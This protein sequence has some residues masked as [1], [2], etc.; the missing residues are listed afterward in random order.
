VEVDRTWL[1]ALCAVCCVPSVAFWVRAR[2]AQA[3]A[4]EGRL[5]RLVD[6]LML[7]LGTGLSVAAGVLVVAALSAQIT[8]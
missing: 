1:W 6:G 3:P 5:Y 4:G 7:G 2:L 8:H